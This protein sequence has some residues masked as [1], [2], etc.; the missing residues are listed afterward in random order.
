MGIDLIAGG[1]VKSGHRKD[2]ATQDVYIKLLVKL[3]RFLERRT[4]SAFN[5]TVLKRLLM[6]RINRPPLTISSVARQLRG[7]E[8][9]VAVLVGTVTNDTRLLEVPKIKICCLRITEAARA[10]VLQAGGQVLTFD[11]LALQAPTGKDAVL[12]RGKRTARVAV[13]YFGAAGVPNSTTRPRVRSNGRK[14]ERA[15]GRRKSCGYKV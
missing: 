11:Q 13:R 12:L 2:A 14:F 5:K 15:R 7:K 3:Y 6:S 9:K 8:D 10:R 1:R 4:N